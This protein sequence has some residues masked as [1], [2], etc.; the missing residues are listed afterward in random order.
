[1]CPAPRATVALAADTVS[2]RWPVPFTIACIVIFFVGPMCNDNILIFRSY[3]IFVL[4]VCV[5]YCYVLFS[6]ICSSYF[7]NI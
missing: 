2:T 6:Y 7:D 5:N 3:C 1:M 4:F